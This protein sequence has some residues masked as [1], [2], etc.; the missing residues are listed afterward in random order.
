M[1]ILLIRLKCTCSIIKQR[2]CA[3]ITAYINFILPQTMLCLE[4][5]KAAHYTPLLSVKFLLYIY[6]KTRYLFSVFSIHPGKHKFCCDSRSTSYAE[7]IIII[8]KTVCICV[9]TCTCLICRHV[10]IYL[11]YT[12]MHTCIAE[13]KFWML[14]KNSAA[15]YLAHSLECLGSS[16]WRPLLTRRL[17]VYRSLLIFHRLEEVY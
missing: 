17:N 11:L 12:C 6:W 3:S 5:R 7:N 4:F 15:R 10:C 8:I 16:G 9:H 1:V 13:G 14:C 2:V